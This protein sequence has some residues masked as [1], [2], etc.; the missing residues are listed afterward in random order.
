MK[1]V[2]SGLKWTVVPVVLV[3]PMSRTRGSCST[4]SPFSKAICEH[5]AVAADLD[6]EPVRE[7]VDAAHADAV[8]AAG[9]LVG[10]LVELAARVEDGH[11]DLD[12]RLALGRVHLDRDAAAVVDDG[13]R[14]VLVDR[15]LDVVA[16]ARE[17]LVD[18]VVHDL[19]DEVVQPAHADVADVHAG[20]LADGLET[21]ENLDVARAVL[22]ATAGG[23]AR[24]R[25]RRAGVGS[26]LAGG[27]GVSPSGVVACS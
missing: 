13:D 11:H 6:V 1:M 23:G 14:V 9:D 17:R 12:G 25:P 27:V 18:G 26:A 2:G 4:V 7:R 21:F 20:P 19:V 8:E 5:A 16:V 3:G 10:V 22:L 24:R 15:D